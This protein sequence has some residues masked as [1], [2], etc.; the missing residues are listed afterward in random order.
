VQGSG[1]GVSRRPVRAAV[2]LGTSTLGCGGAREWAWG[3][4]QA[5]ACSRSAG[6][7]H[8][9]FIVGAVLLS[10][11]VLR[12]FLGFDL[13]LLWRWTKSKFGEFNS[14]SGAR[15]CRHS[16]EVDLCYRWH[17]GDRSA[18]TVV[19]LY[20]IYIYIDIYTY[21]DTE[22]LIYTYWSVYQI[23]IDQHHNAITQLTSP[24]INGSPCRPS[25]SIASQRSTTKGTTQTPCA[26]SKQH[27]PAFE[28][29]TSFTGD[30]PR[31]ATRGMVPRNTFKSSHCKQRCDLY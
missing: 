20:Y 29:N 28:Q 22:I 24:V 1:R 17:L 19:V 18:V 9:W 12:C 8:L 16:S 7:E 27:A 14:A 2:L 31:T 4:P 23:M 26:C 13:V 11:G 25:S 15:I 3:Q 10:L 6:H 21:I 30:L 5:R